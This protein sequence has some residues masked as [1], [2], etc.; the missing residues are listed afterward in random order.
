MN[1]ETR[2]CY[3][4]GYIVF[5]FELILN[6][7]ELGK[8]KDIIRFFPNIFFTMGLL[9]LMVLSIYGQNQLIH[10]LGWLSWKTLSMFLVMF[11]SGLMLI[12]TALYS[13]V[14]K[15]ML[16]IWM[17][18]RFKKIELDLARLKKCRLKKNSELNYLAY[19]L[20]M[21][22]GYTTVISNMDIL[23]FKPF[24]TLISELSDSYIKNGHLQTLSPERQYEI[25]IR[26]REMRMS[27]W[28]DTPKIVDKKTG[29]SLLDLHD[30]LW[31]VRDIE[32]KKK[33]KLEL[34]LARYPNGME[35][36]T[37]VMDLSRQQLLEPERMELSQVPEWLDSKS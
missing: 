35:N 32:W 37:L 21:E 36:Q 29:L 16:R 27:H 25:E 17:P 7:L 3:L 11:V 33:G 8:K 2:N 14:D 18:L 23:R 19:E 24:G 30:S 1:K 15:R 22:D 4:S 13:L 12:N 9:F 20:E 10:T 5:R 31:S 6:I 34:T 26:S 28:V